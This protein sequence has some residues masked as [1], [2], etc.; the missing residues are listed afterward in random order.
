MDYQSHE[1]NLNEDEGNVSQEIDEDMMWIPEY[2]I[3]E[4]IG[5]HRQYG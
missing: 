2:G 1:E 4:E 5:E 3:V